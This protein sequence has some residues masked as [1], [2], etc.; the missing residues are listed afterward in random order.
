MKY[1][2]LSRTFQTLE[3]SRPLSESRHRYG[4][5]ADRTWD[6]LLQLRRVLIVGAGGAGKTFEMDAQC[7]RLRADGECAF[8]AAVSVVSHSGFCASLEASDKLLFDDWQASRETGYFFLDSKDEAVNAGE[9]LQKA[10]RKL[11]DELGA[12]LVRSHIFISTRPHELAVDSDLSDFRKF[13]PFEH[14]YDPNQTPH[15]VLLSVTTPEER[16]SHALQMNRL[17]RKHDFQVVQLTPLSPTD[18]RQY[19]EGAHPQISASLNKFLTS[20]ALSGLDSLAAY[21]RDLSIFASYWVEHNSLGDI[22]EMMESYCQQRIREVREDAA[23]SHTTP[24]ATVRHAVERLATACVLGSKDGVLSLTEQDTVALGVAR[25]SLTCDALWPDL[26]PRDHRSILSRGIF[27]SLVI[28]QLRLN[29]EVKEYLCGCWLIRAFQGAGASRRR[30]KYLLATNGGRDMVL[31][32]RASVTMMLA[33]R[34]DTL[35]DEVIKRDPMLFLSDTFVAR[36]TESARLRALDTCVIRLTQGTELPWRGWETN[37]A[38]LRAFAFPDALL[39]LKALWAEHASASES[40]RK[41]LLWIL[42]EAQPHDCADEALQAAMQT[43][44]GEQTQLLGVQALQASKDRDLIA[45]F[46]EAIVADDAQRQFSAAIAQH[47]VEWL[48]PEYLS[49]PRFLTLVQRLAHSVDDARYGS[50]GFANLWA[51]RVELDDAGVQF[52]VQSIER[53][54]TRQTDEGERYELPCPEN[55]TLFAFASTL[56]LRC[57]RAE[58]LKASPQQN[59]AVLLTCCTKLL[60]LNAHHTS[61]S[62]VRDEIL[63]VIDSVPTWKHAVFWKTVSAAKLNDAVLADKNPYFFVDL[64]PHS[65]THWSSSDVHPL[66]EHMRITGHDGDRKIALKLLFNLEADQGNDSDGVARLRNA[67]TNQP[68]LESLL[69]EWTKPRQPAKEVTTYQR[70]VQVHAERAATKIEEEQKALLLLRARLQTD[71]DQVAESDLTELWEWLCERASRADHNNAN[72]QLVKQWPALRYAFGV[73]A[74]D[75]TR[76]AFRA[77]WRECTVPRTTIDGR[78]RDRFTTTQIALFGLELEHAAREQTGG[79]SLTADEVLRAVECAQGDC[80]MPDWLD[81]QVNAHADLVRRSVGHFVHARLADRNDNYQPIKDLIYRLP[82]I[83]ELLA[84]AL[85]QW[86]VTNRRAPDDTLEALLRVLSASSSVDKAELA[87]VFVT[88]SNDQPEARSIYF[89]HLLWLDAGSA[90]EQASGWDATAGRNPLLDPEWIA[91]LSPRFA[92][93]PKLGFLT[94]AP[95]AQREAYVSVLRWVLTAVNPANDTTHRSGSPSQRKYAEQSR[96]NLLAQL[97]AIPGM[98]TVATLAAL[99]KNSLTR[100]IHRWID[101]M[102]ANR[103]KVDAE[104]RALSSQ[105]VIEIEKYAEATPETGDQLLALTLERLRDIQHYVRDDPFTIRTLLQKADSESDFQRWLAHELELRARDRYLVVRE[106]HSVD[107]KEPDIL[108]AT[109]NGAAKVA[110]EMKLVDKEHNSLRKLESGLSKQLVGQYLRHDS[111]RHGIYVL[112]RQNKNQW[113]TRSGLQL[114]FEQLVTRLSQ[115]AARI[116]MSSTEGIEVKVLATLQK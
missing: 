78:S 80:E 108:L 57:L 93:T 89:K 39:R 37:S 85:F 5:M 68:E 104:P 92:E 6:E 79:L 33:S 14:V 112:V 111:C 110:I 109:K 91:S 54:G 105:Q 101:R 28:G 97:G 18:Q 114:N 81:G 84:P 32:S 116:E 66:Y 49:F 2:P 51:E 41:L 103:L 10:L 38:I 77:H 58:K 65:T 48:F 106:P 69:A 96:D 19:V 94:E 20:L 11:G 47:A 7:A 82:K 25:M 30:N 12:A 73:R 74:A 23:T 71:V 75:R 99:K 27:D 100:P 35:L 1:I 50:F 21:P 87:R 22:P 64:W 15:E 29:R 76:A 67:A 98:A 107:E 95:T 72:P 90:V 4:G 102:V 26:Q 52:L 46:A 43:S 53:I 36:F 113:R 24:V 16:P 8:K 59:S 88:R 44:W 13:C 70:Q 83:R 17:T 9:S 31:S 34:D 86:L 40:A 56:A 55:Q 62:A 45:R 115:K 3:P 63:Q 60:G 61:S 42:C